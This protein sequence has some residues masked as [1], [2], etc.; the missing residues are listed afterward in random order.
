MTGPAAGRDEQV[1]GAQ[2]LRR[3]VGELRVDVDAVAV[4]RRARVTFAPVWP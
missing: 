3:A 4:D 1:V 2:R